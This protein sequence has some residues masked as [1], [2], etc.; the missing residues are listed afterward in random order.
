MKQVGRR[1]QRY[2]IRD[3]TALFLSL[4]VVRL[5][6][7]YS[8]GRQSVDSRRT[9]RTRVAHSSVI[10]LKGVSYRLRRTCPE[11][12]LSGLWDFKISS[13]LTS[14][15][16]LLSSFGSRYPELPASSVS[17]HSSISSRSSRYRSRNFA[18][19]S[20]TIVVIRALLNSGAISKYQ[21]EK[22]RV[23]GCCR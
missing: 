14:G 4:H 13:T 18:S 1:G 15:Q 2:D 16:L 8:W 3:V 11:S 22:Q 23:R 19:S 21:N 5:T 17:S 6:S 20:S 9:E 7:L 12:A 10:L